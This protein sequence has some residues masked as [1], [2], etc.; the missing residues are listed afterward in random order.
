[1]TFQRRTNDQLELGLV[2]FFAMAAG[3]AVA[4]L[5]QIPTAQLSAPSNVLTII[6]AGLVIAAAY[7]VVGWSMF[8]KRK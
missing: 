3:V 7:V 4:I 8:R 2:V 1:M 6:I 5:Y